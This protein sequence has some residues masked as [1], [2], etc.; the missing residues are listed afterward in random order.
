MHHW[1]HL[2]YSSNRYRNYRTLS[3]FQAMNSGK[4]TETVEFLLFS[5][6]TKAPLKT[7]I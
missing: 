6:L 1:R 5:I 7:Y 2:D 3:P 4:Y